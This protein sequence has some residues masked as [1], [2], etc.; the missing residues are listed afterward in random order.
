[1]KKKLSVLLGILIV[2]TLVS[3]DSWLTG[4]FTAT[5]DIDDIASTNDA[6]DTY[7]LDLND[8]EDYAEHRENIESVDQVSIIGWIIN[9]SSNP[10][11]GEFWVAEDDNLITP[12]DVRNSATLIFATPITLPDEN[13]SVFINW[14]DGLGSMVNVDTLRNYIQNVGAFT[15]Y[16]LADEMPFSVEMDIEIVITFTAG[17]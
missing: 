3:C 14:Q 9:R 5:Y 15:V 11:A 6:V 12:D 8:N 13:D 1:M 16:G 7:V 2:L 10:I 4:T 17:R